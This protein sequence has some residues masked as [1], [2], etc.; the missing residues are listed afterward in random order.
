[1]K[2]SSDASEE[3]FPKTKPCMDSLF[4]A[5]DSLIINKCLNVTI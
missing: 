1:M 4:E 2:V 5:L 3:W